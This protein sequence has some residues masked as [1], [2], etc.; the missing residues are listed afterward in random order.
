MADIL[1][2]E[3]RSRLMRRVKTKNTS[4]EVMVRSLLHRL[5]YR[6]VL[7]RA[8]LPGTPDIVFPRRRALIFVHGCF[9]HGH[10]CK[11]GRL[12]KSRQDYWEPKLLANRER[13][14]R[15]EAAL[16][17]AGWRVMTVWQCELDERES[18]THRL[19]EFLGPPRHS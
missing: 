15:K 10:D 14:Q 2:P 9:W 6:F 11:R 17:A 12:P 3:H 8:G 19:V 7:H 1:T 13:D 4:Q 5:G 18:L 16:V